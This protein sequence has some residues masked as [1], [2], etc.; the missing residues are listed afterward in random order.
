MIN[1]LI[2]D[3]HP[4]IGQGTRKMIEDE[5]EDIVVSVH[6]SPNEALKAL[7]KEN[8]DIYLIDLYMPEINGLDLTKLILK[9]QPDA[10][11]LIYTGFDLGPH[12]TL[13]LDAGVSGFVS[14]TTTAEQLITAIKCAM[15]E[16]VV[17]PIELLK[18]HIRRDQL[19][20]HFNFNDD[21]PI[22]VTLNDKE[23]EILLEV[24]KG[25]TNRE[26]AENLIMS[27]RNVEHNLTRIFNKLGVRSRTEAITKVK[28]LGL[29]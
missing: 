11:V 15:R 14:K 24:S 1:L 16:E 8:F 5:A 2:V 13:L 4:V 7:K 22:D 12:L 3:D 27:Q 20:T 25:L 23:R 21:K 18:Q 28:T 9:E 19:D 10:T 29:M 26:I 17:I 6:S